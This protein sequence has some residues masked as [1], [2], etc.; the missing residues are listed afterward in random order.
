MVSQGDWVQCSVSILRGSS[1]GQKFS[2]EIVAW[3]ELIHSRRSKKSPDVA[4]K[5]KHTFS[6]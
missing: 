5:Y 4:V 2:W 1:I 6:E 3:P